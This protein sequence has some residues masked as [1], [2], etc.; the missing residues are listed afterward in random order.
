MVVVTE[1]VERAARLK[2]MVVVTENVER[3]VRPKNYDL[4]PE[5]CV[6]CRATEKL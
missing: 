6:T 1:N 2:T 3:A 5:K 4:G